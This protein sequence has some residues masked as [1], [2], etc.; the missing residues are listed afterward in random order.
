MA[1]RLFPILG[2]TLLLTGKSLAQQPA[3]AFSGIDMLSGQTVSLESYRGK[4]VFI[5]FWAS[6]CPPC[7]LSMPAY[8]KLRSQLGTKQFEIIAINVD[9][10][11]GDGLDFL[12]DNPVSYPVLADPEGEIGIPYGIRSLPVS[13]LLDKSGM[14]VRTYR[15]YQ[16]G[17]ELKIQ[18]DI[19]SLLSDRDAMVLQPGTEWRG[20][21]HFL[22]FDAELT[23]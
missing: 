9:E 10:A 8:D 19:L 6:W 15:G 5:D 2:L 16:P 11:T 13:F 23:R 7:L 21:I 1:C 14:I 20:K 12:I 18:E 4:V 17:D 3:P 22:R